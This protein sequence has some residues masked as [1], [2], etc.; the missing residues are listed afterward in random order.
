MIA[1]TSFSIV[2]STFSEWNLR[3]GPAHSAIIVV[4]GVWPDPRDA[5]FIITG[6][7]FMRLYGF[8][9]HRTTT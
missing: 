4:P 2:N 5:N 8:A 7:K 1:A 3:P 6:N 9:F